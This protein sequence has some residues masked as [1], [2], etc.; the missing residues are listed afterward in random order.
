MEK[1]PAPK[2][3]RRGR[4]LRA[5]LVGGPSLCRYCLRALLNEFVGGATVIE[6]DCGASLSDMAAQARTCDVVLYSAL[7]TRD[8]GVRFLK[9]LAEAAPEIPIAVHTDNEDPDYLARLIAHGVAGII[10][11]TLTADVAAAAL[12]LV[13]AGGTYYPSRMLQDVV[14]RRKSGGLSPAR[15]KGG[16]GLTQRESEV[17]DLIVQGMP[18][19]AVAQ[20]L[21][22]AE[23][24]VKIH[25]QNLF[26]KLK[27]KNRTQAAYRAAQL[28][29][30]RRPADD[31][32]AKPNGSR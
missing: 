1:T 13:A 18:N 8:N 10:P 17:L 16:A 15:A 6:P 23:A 25:V 9:D 21:G 4:P 2:P 5:M 31:S 3:P 7:C 26:K 12:R 32:G 30:E 19:K 14:A 22:L 11:A 28:R 29:L 27:V 20:E 24:T